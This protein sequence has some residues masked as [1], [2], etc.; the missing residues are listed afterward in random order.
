MCSLTSST[1]PFASTGERRGSGFIVRLHV[2][3]VLCGWSH[4]VQQAT[5][6]QIKRI[7]HSW[8]GLRSFVKVCS[9]FS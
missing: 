2:V 4:S 7:T 5:S 9:I 1:W 8:A 6:M 3:A